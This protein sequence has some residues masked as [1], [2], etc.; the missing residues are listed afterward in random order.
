MRSSYAEHN[1]EHLQQMLSCSTLDLKVVNKLKSTVHNTCS[2]CSAAVHLT[3]TMTHEQQLCRAQC[4]APATI[5]TASDCNINIW[6]QSA[7]MQRACSSLHLDVE[8]LEPL[9]ALVKAAMLPPCLGLPP[10]QHSFCGAQEV[11]D[12]QWAVLDWHGS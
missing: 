7:V 8:P 10:L 11:C 4:R 1:A 5:P 6:K 2:K 12:Y 3:G 9:H